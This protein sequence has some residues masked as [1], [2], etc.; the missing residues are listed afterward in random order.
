MGQL[1]LQA[2]SYSKML[3]TPWSEVRMLTG[4][5]PLGQVMVQDSLS[6]ALSSR[7]STVEANAAAII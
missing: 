3:A 6:G 4:C 5:S 1:A 7:S 2:F